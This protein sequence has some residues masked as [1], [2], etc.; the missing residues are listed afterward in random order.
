[1]DFIKWK[2]NIDNLVLN[3]NLKS[4]IIIFF[5]EFHQKSSLS[6]IHI[7]D[8][9]LISAFDNINNY[10]PITLCLDIEFQSA[11]IQNDK[12]ISTKNIKGE[13]TAKFIREIGM[14]F[15]IKDQ[16]L[17]L[18]YIGNLF[19]NFESLVE[20]GFD[21]KTIRLIGAKYADVTDDVYT[22]MNQLEREFRLELL[23]DPLFDKGNKSILIDKIIKKLTKNYLFKNFLTEHKQN[24]IVQILHKLKK[25]DDDIIKKE[26]RYVSKQLNQIQYEIYAKYL[27]GNDLA[28]FTELDKLYW[29]DPLVQSRT[30]LIKGKYDM[31]M[32]LLEELFEESV[33]VIKGK[34]DIIAL[35]NM[36]ILIQ[37]KDMQIDHYYDIETF[38]GFSNAQYHSSQLENTYKGVIET[39]I[40]KRIAKP[41]FDEIIINIGDK[42]HNPVADSLFTIIVAIVMNLGLNDYFNQKGGQYNYLKYKSRYLKLKY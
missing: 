5:K 16:Q 24:V 26:V 27:K 8:S 21:F 1:M 38:N 33:L 7:Q 34:M 41:L 9:H 40:Y 25:T 17:N 28:I 12:Y 22:Q 20:F 29:K 19:L 2:N 3:D 14:L 4:N 15:F 32:E 18:Y 6:F 30:V 35:K 11:I 13:N 37:K 42:A 36:S 23:L 10:K 39:D 31:F